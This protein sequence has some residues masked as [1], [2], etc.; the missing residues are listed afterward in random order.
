MIDVDPIGG[1]GAGIERLPSN[2]V[3]LKQITTIS[4]R[5]AFLHYASG[6][7]GATVRQ[8]PTTVDI[9]QINGSIT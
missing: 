9:L 5:Y 3:N 6:Q 2:V 7:T 1:R 4:T 8:G